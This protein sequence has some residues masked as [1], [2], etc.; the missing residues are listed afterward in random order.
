MLLLLLLLR[1]YTRWGRCGLL[2]LEPRLWC[3]GSLGAWDLI[4]APRR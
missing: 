3:P 4:L 1:K 2:Q